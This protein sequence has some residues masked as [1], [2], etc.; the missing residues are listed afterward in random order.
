MG[1][2]SDLEKTVLAAL[3]A[4]AGREGLVAGAA[5]GSATIIRH[6]R[7]RKLIHAMNGH[8]LITAAGIDEMR[9]LSARAGGETPSQAGA[10]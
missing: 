3:S 10:A 6:L 8:C 7:A 1:Q 4:F 9:R 2:L 5:I